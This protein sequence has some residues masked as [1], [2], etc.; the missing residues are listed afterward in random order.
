MEAKV[1]NQNHGRIDQYGSIAPGDN[2]HPYT[3]EDHKKQAATHKPEHTVLFFSAQPESQY[4]SQNSTDGKRL[5][6]SARN[7]GEEN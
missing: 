4:D 6:K 3:P 2:F 5:K 1:G 7:P